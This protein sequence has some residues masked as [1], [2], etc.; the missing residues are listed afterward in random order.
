[1]KETLNELASYVRLAWDRQ[2]TESTGGNMSVRIGDK[3]Y[4]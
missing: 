1:M 2:L 4:Y 3:V